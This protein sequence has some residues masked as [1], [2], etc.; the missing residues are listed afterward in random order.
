VP[1][2]LFLNDRARA[3]FAGG[4]RPIDALVGI[5]LTVRMGISRPGVSSPEALMRILLA[6]AQP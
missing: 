3:R 5:G 6:G 4:I 1:Q 2:N